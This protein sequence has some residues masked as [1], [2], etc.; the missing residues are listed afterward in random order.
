MNTLSLLTRRTALLASRR[1]A[2]ALST[3]VY[4]A[5]M[6]TT[7]TTNTAAASSSKSAAP[8]PKAYAVEAPD[9]SSEALFDAE[10]HQVEDIINHAAEFEDP[11]FVRTLHQK[12]QD[13]AKIFA[14]DSP[15]GESDD[16][17]LQDQHA[18][19]EVIDYAALHEDKEK[20]LHTHKLEEA[21]RQKNMFERF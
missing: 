19:D 10:Q 15:D 17:H 11:G 16:M 5:L 6:A 4:R 9:G 3:Q 2:P 18:V 13:A 14:V 7:T 21:V 20:V 1:I 8:I 12:Q